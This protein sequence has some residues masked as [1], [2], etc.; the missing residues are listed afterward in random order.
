MAALSVRDRTNDFFALADKLRPS[1]HVKRPASIA[2]S[3]SGGVAG[4]RA[5]ANTASLY[6][7]ASAKNFN[8]ITSEI[9]RGIGDTVARL[10][11]LTSCKRCLV[12][13]EIVILFC[14]GKG[15]IFVQ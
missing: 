13:V 14:S 15:Q 7:D 8:R 4:G 12:F 9:S 6:N 5:S 2:T 3:G 1:V 11:K 10:E